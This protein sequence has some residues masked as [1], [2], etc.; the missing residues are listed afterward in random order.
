MAGIID[1]GGL[2]ECMVG[3]NEGKVD[4]DVLTKWAEIRREKFM[5]Y[6]GPRSIKNMRRLARPDI[7]DEDNFMKILNNFGQNS[8]EM[9]AFLLVSI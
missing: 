2:V 8:E 4:E 7:I 3:I 1:I 9:K 6:I 5:R